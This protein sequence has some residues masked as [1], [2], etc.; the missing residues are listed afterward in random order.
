MRQIPA[1]TRIHALTAAVLV[2]ALAS[3]APVDTVEEHRKLSLRLEHRPPGRT[4]AGETV[5]LHATVQSSLDG[6]KIEAWVRVLGTEGDDE[7]YPLT[8]SGADARCRLPARPKG[9]EI[10]Y[11]IEARDAAGLVVALPRGT[12]EGK[13]YRLRYEGKSSGI[14]GA[15][16]WLAA[17]LGTVLY[18]GAGMAGVQ[19]LR[20]RM[21]AGPAGLLGGLGA[22][23]LVVGLFLLGGLHAFQI[24][25]RLWPDTPVLFALSR[26][27]LGIVTLLWIGNLV[28]GRRVLLDE[29]MGDSPRGER[30]FSAVAVVAAVGTILMAVL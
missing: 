11:V 12:D 29:D 30:P 23:V 19:N 18:V 6:P 15:I 17:L 1:G 5:D 7:I 24:T 10:R 16:A 3:C 27:D 13:S 20:A 28:L 14:L 25:G 26:A 8:L 21:S 22:G 4:P 9:D 2:V